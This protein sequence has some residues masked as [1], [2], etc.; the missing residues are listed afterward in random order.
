MYRLLLPV[1][2][3][4]QVLSPWDIYD[5]YSMAVTRHMAYTACVPRVIIIL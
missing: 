4:V 3:I 2:S 5:I 1:S